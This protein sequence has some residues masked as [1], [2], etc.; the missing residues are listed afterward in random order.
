MTEQT[1]RLIR[2]LNDKSA[3]IQNKLL[4]LKIENERLRSELNQKQIALD[5]SQIRMNELE[6]KYN[7][8]KLAKSLSGSNDNE[9]LKKRIDAMVKEID[10]CIE[11]ID[12]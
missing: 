6:K 9:D 8:L 11:L 3:A 12:E 4:E 7:A 1:E 10:T 5:E 2:S